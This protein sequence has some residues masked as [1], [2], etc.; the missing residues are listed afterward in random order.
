VLRLDALDGQRPPAAARTGGELQTL[1]T[2][3]NGQQLFSTPAVWRGMVFV[4]DGGGTAAY[5]VSG[6]RL[7]AVWQNANNGTSPV[8][9][10]GLLFVYDMDGG[11]IFVYRPA[12][13]HEVAELPA[14]AGHWNSPIVVDGHV[15]EPVGNDNDH[16]TTGE[17]EILSVSR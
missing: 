1:P 17:V 3:G 14:P 10:G 5:R 8:I 16:Q 4:A 11:G 15:I 7:H 12:S 6:G 9:A 2:P 13:G